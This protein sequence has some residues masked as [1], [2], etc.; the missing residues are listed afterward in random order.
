LLDTLP[1]GAD[2][3][4][5]RYDHAREHAVMRQLGAPMPTER[6]VLATAAWL[7]SLPAVPP[8]PGERAEDVAAGRALFE[9]P[10]VGCAGCHGWE[11]L[12]NHRTLDVGTGGAYQ[13]PSLSSPLQREHHPLISGVHPIGAGSILDLIQPVA[14]KR[15]LDEWLRWATRAR[16]APF[17]KL[18]GTIRQH[19]A[20][21]L[22][23]VASGLSNGRSEGLNGK[24]RTL[25]RRAFGFHSAAGLT[26]LILLCCT[27]IKL[28][29]IRKIPA[30]P[31]T[32]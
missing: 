27:G 13:V 6:V 32:H 8:S 29:P 30:I 22:A 21:I 26:A 15:R 24:I 2:G 23:Y 9:S 7:H 31:C 20:G 12:T 25:T 18:A 5:A 10:E 17:V 3:R 11:L 14:A 19:A 28:D 1:H 4:F 16:L